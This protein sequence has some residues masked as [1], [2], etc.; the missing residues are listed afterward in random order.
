MVSSKTRYVVLIAV[1][2]LVLSLVS[3]EAPNPR[4]GN[5]EKVM[6]KDIISSRPVVKRGD[7]KVWIEGVGNFEN[8]QAGLSHLRALACV[9]KHHGEKVDWDWLM[10]VSGEAFCYYYHPDGTYLSQFVHSWDV[11]NAALGVYGYEGTWRFE[12]EPDVTPALE[13]IASEL[14]AGRP[15]IAPG[16]L[17]SSNRINSQCNWWFVVTGVDVDA[18]TVR[19]LGRG[20]TELET[21]LPTGDDVRDAFHPRWYG[22]VRSFE[23]IDGHYGPKRAD[24]PILLV[25]KRKQAA[26]KRNIAL[27]GLRRAVRL[28]TRDTATSR[29]GWGDGTYLGGIAAIQGL[30]DDL[31]VAKGDGLEEYGK[32]NKPKGDPFR[33]L[34]DELEFLKLLSWRRQ[35]AAK[36]LGQCAPTLREAARPHLAAAAKHFQTSAAE[37]MKAFNVRY[38]SEKAHARMGQLFRNNEDFEEHPEW[39][40]Y[41][42]R[43][44]EALA[45]K[46]KRKK[47]ADHLVRVMVSDKAAVLEIEKALMMSQVKREDGKVWIEGAG[48][49]PGGMCTGIHAIT[50]VMQG[51]G[52]EEM[53]YPYLMGVSGMAFRVQMSTNGWCPSSPNAY[54]GFNCWDTVREALPREMVHHPLFDKDPEKV[55]QARAAL[56]A[57]ID[58]GV[59]VQFGSEEDSV[60]VGYA[61]GG[62][63]IL[64]LTLKDKDG[65]TRTREV[66]DVPWGITVVGAPRTPPP[67]RDLV[68]KSLKRA[69]TWWKSETSGDKGQYACGAKAWETWIAGLGDDAKFERMS[70]EKKEHPDSFFSNALGNAWTYE[71]LLCGRKAA[72]AYLRSIADQ[73]KPDAA[74]HLKTAADLCRQ[75]HDTLKA[76]NKHV[77]YPW[78][79]KTKANWTKEMRTAQAEAMKKA[80]EFEEEVVDEIEKA[81]AAEGETGA[82]LKGL[83]Q[84]SAWMTHMGCLIGAA[85]Y[86]KVKASPAWIY[87]GSGYAFTLNIHEVICPSGPTAWPAEKCEALAANVGISTERFQ[88]HKA[89]KDVDAFRESIWKKTR[90]AIDAGRPVYGWEMGVP[91][92]YIVHGYDNDGNYLYRDFGDKTGKRHCT[93]LGDTGIGW[94]AMVIV[95]KSTPADDRKTVREAF[96]FALEHGAGKHSKELWHTG[97]SGYDV[98]IKALENEKYVKED[99]VI[100]FGQAYNGQCWAEC[101]RNAVA[102]LEEAK[103]RLDDEKLAPLFD[104]AI[105]HYSVVR[106]NLNTVGKIFPFK[107]GDEKGMDERIADAS[108]REKAVDALKAA[109]DAER[110]G[111]KTLAKIAVALGA[112]SINPD[113][114]GSDTIRAPG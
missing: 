39:I 45:S 10:G 29:F 50:T 12:P 49:A 98:W 33:G 93:K 82:E 114:A 9:L 17:P 16:I 101:R 59:P 91:E 66:K 69:V 15:V 36:F 46:A 4:T 55:K 34:S 14:A 111:L 71:S 6:M 47:M 83:K 99:K 35:S 23:G 88:G 27:E 100:G 90:E 42:K 92:W 97:I 11:V 94:L 107:L 87:G 58:K 75:V 85:E 89:A 43:A 37:A 51:I 76:A 22:I 79:M 25:R 74:G 84:K 5:K 13:A 68:V 52:E 1:S 104:E 103:K 21:P 112:E 53:T 86:L 81:L 54:C 109:R 70:D 20:K 28:A 106:D 61:D 110:S 64:A 57:S 108:R 105:R 80:F 44:D 78:Q 24:N 72:A 60:C 3:C 32:L 102:F 96:L 41:W 31:L 40:A 30:H 26:D 38:K 63:T 73:F 48:V 62:K 95:G 19:L 77:H 67:R 8:T 7:G 56:V 2:V 113:K 18:R 65:S